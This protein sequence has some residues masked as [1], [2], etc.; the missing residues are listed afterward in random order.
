MQV[1]GPL[2]SQDLKVT[3][4]HLFL[5]FFYMKNPCVFISYLT[6]TAAMVTENG[7][8]HRLK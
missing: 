3:L 8:Q 5:I 7:H 6:L 2:G 1:S 4:Q